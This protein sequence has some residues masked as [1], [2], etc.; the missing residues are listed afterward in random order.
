[1]PMTREEQRRIL[2]P[3]LRLAS[4]ADEWIPVEL[5]LPDTAAAD[6]AAP[7]Q[8]R[9]RRPSLESQVRQLWKA[10]Q[11]AGVQIAV[12]I[13]GDKIT[14]TPARGSPPANREE[15]IHGS[16]RADAAPGRALFKVRA[17]PKAK[18]VL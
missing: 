17:V 10:A 15:P 8:R 13:E 18:V 2:G 14:A 3:S 6:A 16:L 9:I 12:T 1:M 11:A 4:T 5:W 7:K